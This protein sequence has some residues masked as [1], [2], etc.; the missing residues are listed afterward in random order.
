MHLSVFMFSRL[1][2]HHHFLRVLSFV[3]VWF[4]IGHRYVLQ[5]LLDIRL[6]AHVNHTISFIK[7]N[8]GA[9]AQDQVAVLQHIDQTARG[10]DDNLLERKRKTNQ[11]QNLNLRQ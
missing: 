8:V 2:V 4:L 6:K 10:G 3:C 9:A 11:S 1:K 5:N 7:D